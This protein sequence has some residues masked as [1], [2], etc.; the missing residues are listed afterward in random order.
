L[1]RSR[2]GRLLR[3]LGDSPLA[4]STAG[5]N[6]TLLRVT[7]FC[8]SA[9]IAAI[10][11]ALSGMVTTLVS[12][13]AYDPIQS[14]TL[15]AVVLITI[16]SEPWYAIIAGAGIALIPAY[17]TSD[18]TTN[19]LN[20]LFGIVVLL[21]AS[22][23]QRRRRRRVAKPASQ[24]SVPETAASSHVVPTARPAAIPHSAPEWAG[25]RRRDEDLELDLERVSM[26]FG[27]AV[28]VRDLSLSARTGRITG[29]I[30]PN[31]AGKTTTF[32]LCSGL[33]RPQSGRILVNGRDVTRMSVPG[34]ALLGIGRT[35]QQVQLFESMTVRQNVSLGYEAYLSGGSIVRQL[36][37][38]RTDGSTLRDHVNDALQMCGLYDVRGRVV[39]S[40]STGERRLVEIA[41]CLAAPYRLLLLDEPCSGLAL[42]EVEQLGQ[43]LTSI[44]ETYRIGILIVEHQ[45]E[46]VLNM[47]D[48]IYMMNFGNLIFEGSAAEV[49]RADVVRDAYLGTTAPRTAL[50]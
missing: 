5:T 41:R 39:S 21:V 18:N 3:G 34:R 16:G 30:G 2:M 44:V 31:G 40:L 26:R 38:A 14:L 9:F 24:A 35:F 33:L 46:L 1:V 45:V 25:E 20:A 8:I 37:P 22:G 43:L 48:Y 13:D 17:V 42:T 11:G 49:R 27:G 12:G 10:A 6:L 15:V 47:C 23:V 32:N 29:L 7:V 50:E 36:V 19:Y 4:L 28:A